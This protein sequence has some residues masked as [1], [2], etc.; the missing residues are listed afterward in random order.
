MIDIPSAGGLA[1]KGGG[2]AGKSVQF[3]IELEKYTDPSRGLNRSPCG[4]G[5]V[6]IGICGHLRIF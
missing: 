3:W 6:P 4:E 2:V 1:I 5:G